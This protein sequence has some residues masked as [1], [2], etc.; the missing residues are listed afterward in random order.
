[1]YI[2]TE[3]LPWRFCTYAQGGMFYAS[4]NKKNSGMLSG[5]G[6]TLRFSAR[7]ADRSKEEMWLD[8]ER[9]MVST[10]LSN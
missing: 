5:S 8:G 1:M 9:R 10:I 6:H 7:Y 4:N 3:M 2:S